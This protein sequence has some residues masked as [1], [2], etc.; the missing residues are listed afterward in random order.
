MKQEIEEAIR[1]L[2]D[3]AE[4][5]GKAFA[6]QEE[7]NRVAAK[8]DADAAREHRNYCDARVALV[9]AVNPLEQSK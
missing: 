3:A 7:A 5:R 6:V 8:A 9:L 4:R 2:Q 1:E